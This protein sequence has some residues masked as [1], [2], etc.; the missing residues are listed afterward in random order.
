MTQQYR[1]DYDWLW[2]RPPHNDGSL[3][4]VRLTVSGNGARRGVDKWFAQLPKDSGGV[5]GGG[6]WA[7]TEV[8]SAPDGTAVVLDIT[9]GGEDVADGIE[10]GTTHAFEALD[11]HGLTLSWENLPR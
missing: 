1:M 2:T 5:R 11:G 10:W 4:T 9:S 7:V 6:G 3:A 8:S